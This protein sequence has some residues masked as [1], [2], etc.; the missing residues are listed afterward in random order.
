I[1]R[2]Q[3]SYG[4]LLRGEPPLTC[5]KCRSDLSV[6]LGLVPWDASKMNI[7][8]CTY[9]ISIFLVNYAQPENACAKSAILELGGDATITGLFNIHKGP[10]CSEGDPTGLQQMAAAAWIVNTLNQ[11]NFLPGIKIG[12]D[13]YDACTTDLD[14]LMKSFTNENCKKSYNLGLLTIPELEQNL[15]SVSSSN[16]TLIF[17][18]DSQSPK[19]LLI[20]TTVNVLVSLNW[21][22]VDYLF[23]PS[24]AFLYTFNKRSYH[25]GICIAK[26]HVLPDFQNMHWKHL[27]HRA[28]LM[29]RNNTLIVLFGTWE[30]MLSVVEALSVLNSSIQ[31]ILV[32]LRNAYS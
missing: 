13:L 28:V 22:K 18:T 16:D 27:L 15:L 20:D 31:W 8:I 6:E 30:Q 21:T 1:N 2:C 25:N 12:I 23:A 14:E 4:Y 5:D 17:F 32:T 9:V 19:Q 10:N 7:A 24:E 26:Q 11:N 29:E 3:F